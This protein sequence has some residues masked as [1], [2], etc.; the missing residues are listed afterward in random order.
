MSMC[1]MSQYAV[2]MVLKN[3]KLLILRSAQDENVYS[4]SLCS[5]AAA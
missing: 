2:I 4:S 5:H 1:D 3:L